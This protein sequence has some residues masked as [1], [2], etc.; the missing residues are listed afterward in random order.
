MFVNYS[1]LDSEI[2]D[3]FGKRRFN[4]QSNYVYNV[5]FIQEL[6]SL[7]ASFGVTFRKQGDAPSRIVG[8]EIITSYDGDL[9]AFIEK[10]FGKAWAVRLTGINLLDQSK[11]EAFDKFTTIADQISR[12]Y[13][14]YELETETGG[15]AVQLIV[16]YQF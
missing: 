5:G 13:D 3:V 7:E 9:E 14:E 8:E 11:D 1:W 10:R 6:P 15:R 2:E 4:N 16:R 12:D